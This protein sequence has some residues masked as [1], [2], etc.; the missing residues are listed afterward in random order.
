MAITLSISTYIGHCAKL[1]LMLTGIL[2][3]GIPAYTLQIEKLN[4]RENLLKVLLQ[5]VIN[6]G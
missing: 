5:E 4:E 1:S 3:T 6:T 2:C